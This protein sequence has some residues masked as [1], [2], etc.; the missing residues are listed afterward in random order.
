MSLVAIAMVLGS[1][2]VHALWNMLAKRSG[3]A[4][5]FFWAISVTALVVYAVPFAVAA[6]RT[7]W[8][9]DWLRF[10]LA[11]GAIHTGYFAL[12]AAA[13]ARSNLSFAYPIARGTGLLLVPILAVPVFGERP[14]A[15]AWAGIAL[16]AAGILG[17]HAHV[18][19]ALWNRGKV[20]QLLSVPAFLTGLTIALYTLNDTA[21]VH[22]ANPIVY[23]YV[24]YAIATAALTPYVLWSRRA[25]VRQS[26]GDRGPLLIGGAGSY[27]TYLVVLAATRL[28]PVSY[29]APMRETS[30]VI[31]AVL[32]A[33]MLGEPLGVAR[34]LSCL[35][36]VAGVITIALGG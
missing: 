31:G 32:G 5:A 35:V 4:L 15:A 9:W 28:A 16:V 10:A 11:S 25:A 17:L 18:L 19:R 26:L 33:R 13:Y 2:V 14:T 3:D 22:R 20:R 8:E 27:G 1:A 6:Q 30:I 24:V 34:L 36:V 7:P 12:L 21:G 23:L 29:V